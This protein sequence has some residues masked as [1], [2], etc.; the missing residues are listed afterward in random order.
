MSA[1]QSCPQKDVRVFVDGTEIPTL[2]VESH[3]RKEGSLDLSK[4]TEVEF[5]SRWAGENI[6]GV[7]SATEEGGISQPVT[8]E[9]RLNEATNGGWVIAH[10]GYVR[11]VGSAGEGRRMK[12]SVGDYS[13]F[14]GK[15]PASTTFKNPTPSNVLSYIA[16]TFNEHVGITSIRTG[17]VASSTRGIKDDESVNPLNPLDMGTYVVEEY[18]S[19]LSDDH[20]PYGTKTF[21]ANKHTLADVANWLAR[22]DGGYIWF[23]SDGTQPV[24]T[25][26]SEPR[27][28]KYRDT[29]VGGEGTT[30]RV[31]ENNALYDIKP[32][33]ELTVYG[34]SKSSLFGTG[35]IGADNPSNQFPAIT[36]RH[37]TLYQRTGGS[38]LSP[39]IIQK[40]SATIEA[41]T[42]VAKK[43]LKT[44]LNG[45]SGG[46]MIVS[47]SPGMRPYD[48]IRAVPVC[49]EAD[50]DV[51][52]LTYEVERVKH[53][54]DSEQ[55][56]LSEI[57]VSVHADPSTFEIVMSEMKEV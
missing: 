7:I 5:P 10:H 45:A 53:V 55:K 18:L 43:E 49:G 48:T 14:L 34:S 31:R 12:L 16:E 23:G 44:R 54:C 13:D 56:Y 28:Q 4:V 6:S 41:T 40:K 30:V 15:I 17:S 50:T 47:G 29:M 3:M 57:D 39:P 9:Y 20:K 27:R 2:F 22:E 33:T 32:I 11:A 21:K 24:L 52:P 37:P 51:P 42:Q 35:L 36:V 19:K 26:N 25:Y 8:V 38:S 1:V 46:M